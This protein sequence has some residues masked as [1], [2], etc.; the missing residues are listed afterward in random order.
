[1]DIDEVVIPVPT[2]TARDANILVLFASPG[3]TIRKDQLIAL[4]EGDKGVLQVSSPFSGVVKEVQ[5]KVGA[6]VA[7]GAPILTLDRIEARPRGNRESVLNAS[8]L[9]ALPMRQRSKNVPSLTA[10]TR[11]A[12]QRQVEQVLGAP[13]TASASLAV[14]D[15]WA[16]W[17]AFSDGLARK[18]IEVQFQV[19]H[20]SRAQYPTIFPAYERIHKLARPLVLAGLLLIFFQWQTAVALVAAGLA[21]HFGVAHL[22]SRDNA[23]RNQYVV[24]PREQAPCENAM[25]KL[26]GQYILGMAALRSPTGRARWPDYP[27]S[28]LTGKRIRIPGTHFRT[29]R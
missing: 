7:P 5:A 16:H 23:P 21:V 17:K 15:F 11:A 24:Q 13:L 12:F 2:K 26:C 1:M 9:P 29:N 6:R 14:A 10:P 25:A 27:S 3:E 4:L 8:R 28:A 19:E 22:R 20:P 18:E